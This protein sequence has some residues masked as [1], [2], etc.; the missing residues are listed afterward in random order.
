MSLAAQVRKRRQELSSAIESNKV[1][2]PYI[3][4]IYYLKKMRTVPDYINIFQQELE[5][6]MAVNKY[7]PELQG[8]PKSLDTLKVMAT[9]SVNKLIST[10]RCTTGEIICNL[11]DMPSF[12][13]Q[14]EWIEA[15]PAF[16]KWVEV[17]E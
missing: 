2:L 7:E 11:R 5:K 9:E 13:A 6:V 12:Y 1:Y 3:C 8:G 14:C 10:Y 15:D 4:S 17:S 16:I